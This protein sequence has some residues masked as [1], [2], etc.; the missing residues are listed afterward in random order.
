MAKDGSTCLRLR[1]S[2][3]F[4]VEVCVDFIISPVDNEQTSADDDLKDE[5]GQ[6]DSHN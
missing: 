2:L 6:R 5:V 3:F 1:S 4:T